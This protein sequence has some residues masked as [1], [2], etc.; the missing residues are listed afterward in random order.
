MA[1]VSILRADWED[2]KD[3]IMYDILE[4]KFSNK[5]LAQKLLATGNA[6]L[7]EG[8]TWGDTYWGA[9]RGQGK[10]KLGKLLMKVRKKLDRRQNA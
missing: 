8:N 4:A 10:N 9:C 7:V 2:K 1:G 6:K 5:R 3:K